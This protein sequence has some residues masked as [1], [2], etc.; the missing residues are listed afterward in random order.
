M[1]KL[2]ASTYE[3]IEK[4]GSGGGGNVYLAKHQ[5]LG[6]KVVLKADKRKITARPELLR[7]E[8][9]VLKELSHSYIPQ[10]YDFFIEDDIVYTV[11]AYIEGESLD[12]PLKRGE[13][14]SQ[15]QVIK[16]AKQLLEALEYLH[17]PTHGTP[18]RGYVHSDIK[19]ANI[20]RTPYDDICLIDFNITL[21]LG[22]ENVVGCSA[23]YASPEHYGLDFSSFG[24]ST[25]TIDD[26]ET[27]TMLDETETLTMSSAKSNSSVRKI[28]PDIRS[29]IYSVG[30][31]LYHLLSGKRP[32]RN[33]ME[34]APLSSKEFSPQIV[35]IISKAMNPNPDLRYQTAGEMLQ[36]LS[37]LHDNDIRAKRLK[38][39]GLIGGAIL[40]L[41]FLV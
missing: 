16:W 29:D 4:I 22:E 18:P 9:D 5:R 11:M 27:V 15:P 20:M 8:V 17:S 7:R 23:G 31:T 10:V 33:A 2:I 34:V 14:F 38:R 3:V 21:A 19:P 40:S 36:E 1:S 32:A 28:V 24:N 25:A 26:N 41:M 35:K 12:R 37:H 30:A 13:K 6:K 39:S